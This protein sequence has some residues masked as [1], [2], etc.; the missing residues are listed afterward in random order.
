MANTDIM[1]LLTGVSRQGINPVSPSSSSVGLSGGFRER[2]L[3]R[4][5]QRAERLGGAVRG[6]LSSGPTAQEQ[7]QAKMSEG[8]LNFEKK[9]LEEQK[10]LIN[11]LRMAGQTALA[12]QLAAQMQA[13]QTKIAEDRRRE[14]LL[15]QA[16]KLGLEN[17]VELLRSGG[18][19][20]EAAK[21]VRSQEE[22][23]IVSKQ[24]RT[25]K[26]ALARSRNAGNT[27]IQSITKGE[28]DSLSNEEFLE[29][30]SG[31]KAD[32]KVYQGADGVSKPYRVN[33]AGKVFN[34]S[35]EKWVFPSELGLTQAAQVTRTITDADKLSGVLKEKATE[36]FLEL[37]KK[38]REAVG[39][40]QTNQQSQSLVEEGLI[41][42][43][44]GPFLLGM[45]RL[46]KQLGVVPE[47]VEDSVVATET[48]I[49]TRGKQVLNI[50]STGAV[51]AGTGISDKDVQFLKEIAAGAITLDEGT[52]RRLLR[53]EEAAAR[54]AIEE[55]NNRLE[56]L[57][58]FVGEDEDP[59]I[60][61]SLFIPLPEVTTNVLP[62]PI[63]NK[64]LQQVREARQQ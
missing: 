11:A 33:E 64:Y 56:L 49:A 43:F 1:G 17:T 16:G 61:D 5:A 60:I 39:V 23:Q 13:K 32:L 47:S 54:Y 8:I 35:T 52:I 4:G 21:Q 9:P 31:Q 59:A 22:K 38:G 50:L 14:G 26:V 41:T 25:G 29:V 30:I 37:N 53:I 58:G 42:G 27:V 34:E 24:G 57:K 51:G 15:E 6:L 44:G 40:L 2:M 36:D 62:T 55:S 63:A 7:I 10:R 28:Y 20:D 19:L 48:F 3:Q 45:A 46:G 12:G 18:S